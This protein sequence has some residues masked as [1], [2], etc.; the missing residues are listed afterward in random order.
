MSTEIN[1]EDLFR[2][3]QARNGNKKLSQKKFEKEMMKEL[4]PLGVTLEEKWVR[5][6]DGI[7]RRETVFVGMKMRES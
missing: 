4:A 2:K 3:I 7:L 5:G 6:K 1:L